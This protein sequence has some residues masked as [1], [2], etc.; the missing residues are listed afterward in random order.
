VGRRTFESTVQRVQNCSELF[1]L[2]NWWGDKDEDEEGNLIEIEI[3]TLEAGRIYAD[4]NFDDEDFRDKDGHRDP[5]LN[6]LF[7]GW[8]RPG[9]EHGYALGAN[10][11]PGYVRGKA[12]GW[13][14]R[15]LYWRAIEKIWI[16]FLDKF[17]YEKIYLCGSW[18]PDVIDLLRDKFG[19]SRDFIRRNHP[20]GRAPRD[21]NKP[22]EW[23]DE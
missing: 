6:R 5:T 15:P 23:D 10:A 7:W 11:I 17:T 20:S 1:L 2:N 13:Y 9:F 16:P 12:N 18:G 14:S 4:H 8:S 21:W 3:E 19:I 22:R